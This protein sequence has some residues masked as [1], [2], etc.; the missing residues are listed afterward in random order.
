MIYQAIM[1]WPIGEVR[2][3]GNGDGLH[4]GRALLRAKY[5][6][7][8]RKGRLQSAAVRLSQPRIGGV[9]RDDS[10]QSEVSRFSDQAESSVNDPAGQPDPHLVLRAAIQAEELRADVDTCV[11]TARTDAAEAHGL[12]QRTA[13][14]ARTAPV[15]RAANAPDSGAASGREPAA[16]VARTFIRAASPHR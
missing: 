15:D 4:P 1:L 3:I 11:L 16:P 5:P 14:V 2:H 13:H 10:E 6:Y 9:G 12:A 8:R 7:T